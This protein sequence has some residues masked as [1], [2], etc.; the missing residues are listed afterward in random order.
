MAKQLR[1]VRS[2]LESDLASSRK[3]FA[4]LVE[5]RDGLKEG[6][7]ESVSALFLCDLVLLQRTCFFYFVD[8][9][10]GVVICYRM[11]ERLLKK[12]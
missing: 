2:K 3:R 11:K 12:S 9:I 6:R 5:Q 8:L 1:N 4:E 10:S 7:E